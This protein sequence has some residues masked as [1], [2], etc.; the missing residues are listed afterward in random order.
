MTEHLGATDRAPPLHVSRNHV[1]AAT[2]PHQDQPAA[3]GWMLD[4]QTEVAA[5]S[6][7]ARQQGWRPVLASLG[8]RH[9]DE[10]LPDIE[11]SRRLSGA[12]RHVGRSAACT[13]FS[14]VGCL[15]G[16]G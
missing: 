8:A 1:G 14:C 7:I 5:V 15:T 6:S 10:L 9:R 3:Y 13:R 11:A 12:E 16:R 2:A 4:Q